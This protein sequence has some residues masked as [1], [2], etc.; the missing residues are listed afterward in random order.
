MKLPVNDANSREFLKEEMMR[1]DQRRIF[2]LCFLGFCALLIVG[3][4][5]LSVSCSPQKTIEKTTRTVTQTTQKIKHTIRFSD[6]D[7]QR[8]A[9]VVGFE[10]RS[11][12]RAKDFAQLFRKGIPEYLNNECDDV[13]VPDLG[14]SENVERLK[15]LPRL[16]SGRVDNFTLATIGRQ[17]GLNAVV[18]GSLDDIGLITETQGLILKDTL[19]SIQIL[20]RIHVYDTETGSKILD[21]SFNRKVEIEELDY[22]LMRSE[23]K[24][25]LPDLNETISDLLAEMGERIC[26]AIEEQPWNGF[27]ASFAGDKVVLSAGDMS[28]LKPGD[29]LE[30]FDNTRILKGRDGQQFFIHGEKIGEIRIV[31]VEP[32]SSEAVVVSD[33]GIK[34]GSSVRVK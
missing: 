19:H 4:N 27:I 29:E 22:D 31:A 33:N 9:A 16:K 18:T 14:A 6:D 24:L 30:V 12:Y 10:N 2:R 13:T 21:E 32:D 1:I 20:V 15:G 3:L 25:I 28:G 11:L 17:L 8:L 5:I 7:L 34:T 26:W 23:E